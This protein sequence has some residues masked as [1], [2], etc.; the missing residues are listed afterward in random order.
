MAPI[1]ESHPEDD[2]WKRAIK[3]EEEDSTGESNQG[4]T[5]A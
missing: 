2:N 5:S 1:A 3:K 4:E